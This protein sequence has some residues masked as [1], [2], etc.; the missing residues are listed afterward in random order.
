MNSRIVLMIIFFAVLSGL[1]AQTPGETGFD[2]GRGETPAE[3]YFLWAQNEIN[4]G[5]WHEAAAALERA[6]DFSGEL[7]DI[8]FLRAVVHEHDNKSRYVVLDALEQ[9]LAVSRW[10]FYTEAEARFKAAEYLI[11]LRRYK[12]AIDQLAH[13]P[14]S[15][16]TAVLKLTALKGMSLSS[17]DSGSITENPV[18]KRAEFRRALLETMDRYP[19]DP[20]PVRI[21]FDYAHSRFSRDEDT[22]ASDADIYLLELVLRRLPLVIEADPELAWKASPFIRDREE[23]RRYLAAYRAGSLTTVRADDFRPNPA[24]IACALDYS[25]ISD[26]QATE[27][28][29]ELPLIDSSLIP[30][31]GSRMSSEKS[32]GLFLQR[33]LSFSGVI[34]AD[35][36]RD[37]IPESRAHYYDGALQ[38]Y[39]LDDD[40]DGITDL[41]I[42]CIN[43]VPQWAHQLLSS[44]Q[45]GF[46]VS[47]PHTERLLIQWER[48]PYVERVETGG[49]V[50]IARPMEFRYAPVNFEELSGSETLSGLLFPRPDDSWNRL[51]R[52]TLELHALQIQRP[53]MEFDG[54]V[55]WIDFD[56]GIPWRATEY[57]SGQIIAITEYDK[58]RPV[59]QWVDLDRDSRMETMRRFRTM[60][61]SGEDPLGYQ[62]IIESSLSDW[63]GDGVFEYLEEYL[64][65]GSIVYYW[66]MDGGGLSNYA[67]RKAETDEKKP[68]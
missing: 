43:G 53:S 41:Y 38:K 9:A 12:G 3:R 16:D 63:N 5:R 7:S 62:K 31:V 34:Y 22:G 14:A 54:A 8:S 26:E 15:A 50:Y 46:S 11:A 64:S 24:S 47:P 59:L 13:I 58:G 57:I 23:A 66:D 65:D 40:Q 51:T 1:Y 55:E 68:D 60:D 56:R 17:A 67:E 25:L 18:I 39:F 61:Y 19:R 42:L 4:E 37:G 27:E 36:D 30:A 10:K 21:F 49:T 48:Y 20:R 2:Q 35:S 44:G 6:A 33:L 28:L 29:F 52:R 45:A 32:T